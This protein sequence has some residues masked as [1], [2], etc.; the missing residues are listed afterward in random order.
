MVEWRRGCKN[1]EDGR[2]EKAEGQH[3]TG[4]VSFSFFTEAEVILEGKVKTIQYPGSGSLVMWVLDQGGL[5]VVCLFLGEK[6]DVDRN[7]VMLQAGETV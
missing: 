3:L 1:K 5:G 6:V 2:R 7:K 4:N